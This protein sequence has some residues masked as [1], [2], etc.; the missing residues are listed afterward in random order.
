MSSF[1]IYS[2]KVVQELGG[3]VLP[4]VVVAFVLGHKAERYNAELLAG[5]RNKTQLYGG[6]KLPEGTVLWK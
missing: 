5:C 3:V 2:R 4:V 6:R 1:A